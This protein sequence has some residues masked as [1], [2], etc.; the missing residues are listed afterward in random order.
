MRETIKIKGVTQMYCKNCGTKIDDES[1]YCPNCGKVINN[2]N[3]TINDEVTNSSSVID[4]IKNMV[5]NHKTIIALILLL[6]LSGSIYYFTS[7]NKDYSDDIIGYWGQ[8]KISDT[9]VQFLVLNKDKTYISYYL[10]FSSLRYQTTIQAKGTGTYKLN[11]DNLQLITDNG[12]T[13]EYQIDLH[14]DS[15]QVT[16]HNNQMIE[17]KKID[18]DILQHYLDLSD[19]N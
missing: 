2:E 6:V 17:L 8:E 19:T 5:V 15:L 16:A 7:Q 13:E 1:I 14:D 11:N 9:P 10:S 3:T 12:I 18:K 4:S